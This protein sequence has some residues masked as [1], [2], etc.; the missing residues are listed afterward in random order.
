[1]STF[2]RK[3][4]LEQLQN[5]HSLLGIFFRFVFGFQYFA[6]RSLHLIADLEKP[7]TNSD[8]SQQEQTTQWT[9]RIP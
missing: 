1:M 2:W 5:T 9:N 6:L 8:Q 3:L 4:A 7:I